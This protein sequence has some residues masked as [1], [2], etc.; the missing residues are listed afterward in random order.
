MAQYSIRCNPSAKSKRRRYVLVISHIE[1]ERY[2]IFIIIK[3]MRSGSVLSSVLQ[4]RSSSTFDFV[5]LGVVDIFLDATSLL[6][7]GLSWRRQQDVHLRE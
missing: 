5:M 2:S 4:L 6:D 3:P 1:A 7:R